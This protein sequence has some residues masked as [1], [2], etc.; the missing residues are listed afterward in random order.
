MRAMRHDPVDVQVQ[1]LNQLLQG[2]YAYYGMA[3]N[4][5]AL[6]PVYQATE[7]YWHRLLSSRS[8]KSSVTW[9]EFQ[10]LKQRFPL[11]RPQLFLSYQD[12]Q[13]YAIL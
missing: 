5:R 13:R 3:G 11:K 12:L 2:H 7:S 4:M 9:T 6:I 10:A 1:V 8:Q